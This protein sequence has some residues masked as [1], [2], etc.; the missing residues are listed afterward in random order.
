MHKGIMGTIT[1]T[2]TAKLYKKSVEFMKSEG[3]YGESLADIC[4]RLITE[5]KAYR[6]SS[7]EKKKK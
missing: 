4:E 3:K 5:L 6:E 2:T 7:Q 1:E